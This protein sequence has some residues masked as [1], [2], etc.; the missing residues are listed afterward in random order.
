MLLSSF[1]TELIDPAVKGTINVLK[2]CAK[3][4]SLKRVI[5]TSSIATVLCNEKPKTPE[6][7]VD[8][9]WFSN[10]DFCRENEVCAIFHY[11]NT[12]M[13]FVDNVGCICD[14]SECCIVLR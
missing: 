9:T 2:S 12:E 10:P 3:S 14:Y 6:V 7:V 4:P 5:L 13:K 8:E 11:T 1:Q